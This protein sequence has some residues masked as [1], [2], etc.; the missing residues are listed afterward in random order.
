KFF[1][2]EKYSLPQKENTWLLCSENQIIWI[3]GKRLDNR[4]RVSPQTNHILKITLDNEEI[5]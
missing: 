2:D 4:F 5:Y 3:I 1:K